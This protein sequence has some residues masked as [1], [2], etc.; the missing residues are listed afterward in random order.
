M[1]D[2][3]LQRTIYDHT[4]KHKFQLL[5]KSN[6]TIWWSLLL[7]KMSNIVFQSILSTSIAPN[8]IRI[9]TR[10][11][12]VF[13]FKH[14]WKSFFSTFVWKIPQSHMVVGIRIT[15]TLC[16]TFI[17]NCQ[18]VCQWSLCLQKCHDSDRPLFSPSHLKIF[19][20]F[21]FTQSIMSIPT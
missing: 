18:L 11:S 8:D 17:R 21:S 6:Y 4:K 10:T 5:L 2:L 9:C 7:R 19:K 20:Q 3:K 13:K 12:N 1:Y 14:H 16:H 15:S